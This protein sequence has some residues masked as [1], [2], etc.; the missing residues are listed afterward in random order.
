M[1]EPE[2]IVL[3]GF[4]GAGKSSVGRLLAGLRGTSFHDLDDL[5]EREAGKEVGAIFAE[6]GE[7]AFR[8]LEE[9]ALTRWLETGRGVLATGGGVVES[10]ACRDRLA[11][12]DPVLWLDDPFDVFRE[13]L[14]SEEAEKRPLVRR[15]GLAGLARLHQRRRR[16]YAH[17]ADFRLETAGRR[18]AQVARQTLRLL[19][20]REEAD[21]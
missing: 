9:Q 17:C 5:V 2:Q 12:H 14:Q 13:R 4:M 7:P 16:L 1:A 8:R 3:I 6:D 10:T 19:A 21:R 18:P 20:A 11:S 15:L